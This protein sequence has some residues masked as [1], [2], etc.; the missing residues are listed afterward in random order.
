MIDAP[1]TYRLWQH[2]ATLMLK[3]HTAME[4]T[5]YCAPSYQSFSN[6]AHHRKKKMATLF[7]DSHQYQRRLN[8]ML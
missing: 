7:K 3:V 8:A 1:H 4:S 5:L 6:P 2:V